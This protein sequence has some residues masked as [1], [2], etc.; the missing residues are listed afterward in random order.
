M[1]TNLLLPVVLLAVV[2]T[3]PV[4]VRADQQPEMIAEKMAVKFTRGLANTAT[5]IVEIPK[6]SMLTVRDMGGAGYVVGPAKG[7]IMTLY[8][9][10]I[11]VT[12]ALFFL[13]PQP[14]Y[15]DPMI[16]P[17]YVWEGWEPKRD[18]SGISSQNSPAASQQ[19][20]H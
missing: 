11:G 16:E 15:Y 19:E 17:S 4:L 18:M 14:G 8:R 12:E 3:V 13:V 6:Q 2:L 7:V 5:C 10:F 9:G 20:A 1:K